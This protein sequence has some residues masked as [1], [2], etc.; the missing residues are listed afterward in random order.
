MESG[1]D[2]AV[3]LVVGGASGIGWATAQAFAS[4]G[5]RV[6]I[7]DID[8]RAATERARALPQARAVRV[9]V[10]DEHDVAALFASIVD[11]DG[12]VD[13]VVNCAGLGHVAFIADHDLA[14]WK[15]IIDVCLT[16]AFLVLK[17]AARSVSD[18][19]SIVTIASLNARQAAEGYGA[20][21]AAK[22][23][24]CALVEVAALELG[25]RG[26]RVNTVSPGLIDTPLTEELKSIPG[27]QEEF[28]DNTPLGRNGKPEDIAAVA[29]FLSSIQ[30]RWIT[31][32]TV[33]INGGAH[34]RRYPSVMHH[35]SA[36][37]AT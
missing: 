12:H 16:G 10:T 25:H 13:A 9:D 33:D 24:V 1:L 31:G 36:L 22:R 5:A 26:V 20:Y 19:G 6:I 4:E 18:N 37:A 2:G 30:S 3:A 35:L 17:Y 8:E 29:M 27:V 28:T 32:E 15:R 7:A 21:S 11:T 34:L 23:G 14:D